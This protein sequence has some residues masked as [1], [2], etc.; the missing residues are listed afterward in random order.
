MMTPEALTYQPDYAVPPGETLLEVLDDRAMTQADLARRINRPA[1]TVNEIIKGKAAL[2]AETALQLEAVLAVP[3]TFWINRE[4]R[5]REALARQ[6][7]E[8]ELDADVDCVAGFP[9]AALVKAKAVEA[10]SSRHEKAENL[11]GF[12]GVSSLRN[13]GNLYAPVFRVAPTKTPDPGSLAAWLR[14]G[15]LAAEK[16][17]VAS[18]DAAQLQDRVPD[19]R[20]LTLLDPQTA[21]DRLYEIMA[22]CGVLIALVPHLPK[23]YAHGATRRKSGR[24]LIQVSL[25]GSWEDVFWFS[26]FHEIAHALLRHDRNAVLIAWDDEAAKDE[27]ECEADGL[28]SDLLIPPNAYRTFAQT[29]VFSQGRVRQFAQTIG[30]CPGVV[31]GRLQHEKLLPFRT[32]LNDLRRRL[33]F[34]DEE[35]TP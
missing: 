9:Y 19:L 5:Y 6:A 10:A 35:E 18:Y 27:A 29:G 12:F 22:Q 25:R 4:A 13:V 3:A 31:V 28:A 11:R 20:A 32:P 17:S 1:K 15:E 30:V 2:T 26:L 24:P 34:A 7:R 16:T 14:L 33:R 21:V 23:T 8:Q